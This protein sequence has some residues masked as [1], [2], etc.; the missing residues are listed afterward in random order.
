MFWKLKSNGYKKSIDLTDLHIG[1]SCF[2]LGSGPTLNNYDLSI[3]HDYSIPTIAINNAAILVKPTYWISTDEPICFAPSIIRDPT[4]IKF[5]NWSRRDS[6]INGIKWQDYPNTLFYGAT[7][8]EYTIDNFFFRRSQF[9]WWKNTWY[10]ALQLAYR[11]GFRTVYTIGTDFNI[12]PGA[13]Y[14]FDSNLSPK[15]LKSNSTL[16][17]QTVT[18]MVKLRPHFKECKFNLISCSATSRLNKYFEY[19]DFTS[20]VNSLKW[21]KNLSFSSNT[22][23]HSLTNYDKKIRTSS[24]N[25]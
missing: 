20:T 24:S 11:L 25:S 4:Y 13:Q 8:D 7:K 18:K 10:I 22:L 12:T 9:V 16:Y 3:F 15:E 21:D 14:A 2:L 5:A 6:K 17:N 1:Q 23:P 19:Q